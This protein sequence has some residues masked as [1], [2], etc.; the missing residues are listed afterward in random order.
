MN[1]DDHGIFELAPNGTVFSF[2]GNGTVIDTKQ[3][4]GTEFKTLTGCNMVTP[5]MPSSAVSETDQCLKKDNITIPDSS[6][7]KKRDG[8]AFERA[9]TCALFI[10]KVNADC[11]RISTTFNI[12]CLGCL[13][14][15]PGPNVCTPF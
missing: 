7:S 13:R 9:L 4:D 5:G 10:C 15:L 11:D 8:E 6:V 3:L 14:S 2:D 12:R 1:L